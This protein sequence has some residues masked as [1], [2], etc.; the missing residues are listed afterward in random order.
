MSL[1]T[2]V[3]A[4][5]PR[6]ERKKKPSVEPQNRQNEANE[7]ATTSTAPVLRLRD[8]S[9]LTQDEMCEISGIVNSLSALITG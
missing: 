7:G 5:R 9:S 6:K 2:C 3:L 8:P 1:L 4:N